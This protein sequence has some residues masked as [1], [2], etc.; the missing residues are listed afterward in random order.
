VGHCHEFRINEW[1][2]RNFD[3]AGWTY[4]KQALN[5]GKFA[6]VSEV[7]RLHALH[8]RGGVYLDTDVEVKR[9]FD[10]LLDGSVVLGFG[11]GSTS[12]PAP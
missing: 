3:V 9:T 1:N 8:E 12:L 10:P 7:A 4:A 2:E 5:A 6:F 11:R